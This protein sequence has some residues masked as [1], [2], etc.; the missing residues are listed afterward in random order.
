MNFSLALL[1]FFAFS[2]TQTF[3]S[4]NVDFSHVAD[5]SFFNISSDSY[6]LIDRLSIDYISFYSDSSDNQKFGVRLQTLNSL[7]LYK[8]VGG[9][10]GF[11]NV[12]LV[13]SG[14]N[15]EGGVLPE[16]SHDFSLY[17]DWTKFI[18]IEANIIT[19]SLLRFPPS[20]FDGKLYYEVTH[21]WSLFFRFSGVPESDYWAYTWDFNTKYVYTLGVDSVSSSLPFKSTL[22]T[23][24]TKMSFSFGDLIADA[25]R[26]FEGI[27]YDKGYKTGYDDALKTIE[28]ETFNPIGQA[29]LGVGNLLQ[30]EIF[31]G[32]RFW[33]LISI[34]ALMALV[35]IVLKAFH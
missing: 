13:S 31:P 8:N 29:F 11:R 5:S 24:N 19:S 17:V 21:E 4:E 20:G 18:N 35:F 33:Y 32:F 30:T 16:L 7:G 2:P 28:D 22:Y 25:Q 34:P 26:G 15:Y 23:L 6:N 27:G 3:Y 12:D 10:L 1:P 14:V 9:Y